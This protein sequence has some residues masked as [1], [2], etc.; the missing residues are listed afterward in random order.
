MEC[1][2][3]FLFL[4]FFLLTILLG[5]SGLKDA[6]QR[7]ILESNAKG[8]YIYRHHDEYFYLLPPPVHRERENYPWE[9]E[10]KG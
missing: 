7:R 5:C 2:I 10:K 9:K 1:K 6:E 8:E 4:L 3:P